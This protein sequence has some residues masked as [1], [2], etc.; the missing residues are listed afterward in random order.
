MKSLMLPSQYSCLNGHWET[1]K[2]GA[3]QGRVAN[4]EEL[5]YNYCQYMHFTSV[6]K[7]WDVTPERARRE[8]PNA[9]PLFSQQ[10]D[11]W[12]IISNEVCPK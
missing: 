11:H 12:W 9:H 6:A 1:S 4:L 10:F 8:R 3:F 5:Y 7:P 2:L